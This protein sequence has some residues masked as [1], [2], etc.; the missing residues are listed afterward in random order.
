[1][2]LSPKNTNN[3]NNIHQP[4]TTPTNQQQQHQPTPTHRNADV[5]QS[6]AVSPA[7]KTITFPLNLGNLQP[8]LLHMPGF[9]PAATLGKKSFEV[10]KP[11]D[12]VNPL[13]QSSRIGSETLKTMQEM[14]RMGHVS[15]TSNKK[16]EKKKKLGSNQCNTPRC[17]IVQFDQYFQDTSRVQATRIIKYTDFTYP[18]TQWRPRPRPPRPPATI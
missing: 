15:Q 16:I 13:K 12:G 2:C 8:L 14:G 17:T 11:S 7:P 1:M 6:K 4:T 9:E 3:N 10:Q 5:A 18:A